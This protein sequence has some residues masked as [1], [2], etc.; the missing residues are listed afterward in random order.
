MTPAPVS[1]KPLPPPG[2]RLTHAQWLCAVEAAGKT[3]VDAAPFEVPH[4]ERCGQI[5]VALWHACPD[6]DAEK[7]H[8]AF[9][10]AVLRGDV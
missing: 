2:T 3:V 10:A 6:E 4:C 5:V 7:V 9:Y 8:D 1:L